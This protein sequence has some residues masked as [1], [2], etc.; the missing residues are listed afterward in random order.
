MKVSVIIPFREK[1]ELLEKCI[2]SVKEQNYK[3]KEIILVSDRT[4]LN[5]KGVISVKNPDCKGVGAKRNF[6]G[7]VAKGDLLFF[8]DS[9]CILNKGTISSLVK[10]LEENK[11]DAISGKSLTP[12]R[13][14]LL[15]YVTGLE[16]EYRFEKMGEGFV[17]VAATT[18][19]MISRKAFNH[20]GG[21]VDYSEGEAVGEDWDFSTKL[22]MQKFKIFHTNK[23]EF[24]HVH[25]SDTLR[26]YLKRQYQHARYRVTHFRRYK[27]ATDKYTRPDILI[28]S[29]FLF[30]LVPALKIYEK[31]KDIKVLILLP[32]ISLLRSLA[33][34]CGA[35]I[36]VFKD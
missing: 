3:N 16:Y 26:K 11:A 32:A 15:G 7:K 6:G 29:I 23:V 14:N 13:S 34:I 12:T 20:I 25:S 30:N 1:N 22:V 10:I 36:G 31:T 17:D 18:C 35:V 8:L 33:W 28:S 27:Q 4:S 9:D 2:A 24:Y 21:F 19:L 5:E